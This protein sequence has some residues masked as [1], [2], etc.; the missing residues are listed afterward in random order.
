MTDDETAR[1]IVG[2]LISHF[3]NSTGYG[4]GIQP[5]EWGKYLVEAIAKAL[6]DERE[7]CAK[8][9]DDWAEVN[10]KH[11]RNYEAEILKAGA[12]AIRARGK[13]IDR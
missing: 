1:A 13:G 4:R 7:G 3:K 6:Q 11:D 8:I 9:M 12:G 10:M 2:D 5:D